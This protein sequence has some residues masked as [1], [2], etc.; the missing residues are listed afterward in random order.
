MSEWQN[1]I[2]R[3]E[4]HINYILKSDSLNDDE[5]R[6]ILDGLA[7]LRNVF[8]DDWLWRAAKDGHPLISYVTNYAPWSQLWLAELGRRLDSIK[9]LPKFD[10]LKNRLLNPK[11]YA[12][13]VM[14]VDLAYKLTHAGFVVELYPQTDNKKSD[15]KALIG[16]K[17]VFFEVTNLQPTLKSVKASETFELLTLPYMF[18]HGVI[19]QCQIHKILSKPHIKELRLKIEEAIAEVKET[20]DFVYMGEPNVIDYLILHRNKQDDLDSLV[21]RYGMKREITGPAFDVDDV[22][23]L[24]NKIWRKIYQLPKDKPSVIVIYGNITY[25]FEKAE[26]HYSKIAYDIEEAIYSQNNLISGIIVGEEAGLREADTILRKPNYV[27]V[28]KTYYN[29]LSQSILI[30]KNRYSVFPFKDELAEKLIS[31]F[32]R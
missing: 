29:L 32:T 4:Y 11:E 22:R 2:G 13:A 5:K 21:G 15:M 8:T 1:R 7:K 23:R 30:I 9:V 6:G 25:F 10:D 18:D 28:R 14:E 19:I 12:G 26:E 16:D 27:F 3:W 20:K 31:A 24:E 17:E